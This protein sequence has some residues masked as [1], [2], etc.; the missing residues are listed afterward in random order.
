MSVIR[1]DKYD[2]DFGSGEA[3]F[4][5]HPLSPLNRV[6]QR[7]AAIGHALKNGYFE[8][9]DDKWMAAEMD[10]S[11]AATLIVAEQEETKR[12]GSRD[13]VEVEHI[14]ADRDRDVTTTS[15][16]AL[17]RITDTETGFA[18]QIERERI[19]AASEAVAR[20]CAAD[21][22]IAELDKEK[23]IFTE[24]IRGT[25]Q[26]AVAQNTN[27]VQLKDSQGHRVEA[28]WGGVK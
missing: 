24:M 25:V 3:V 17:E 1:R 2:I 7:T 6:D 9:A 13:W 22:R 4:P 16:T 21:T 8:N 11:R 15:A 10:R 14:R 12:A 5:S 20:K 23:G 26:I 27:R 19:K 28:I 18:L